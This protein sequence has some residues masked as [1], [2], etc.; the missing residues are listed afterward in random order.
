M[1]T[2]E[3]PNTQTAYFENFQLYIYDTVVLC[4]YSED[5]CN[6]VL[7]GNKVSYCTLHIHLL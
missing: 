7:N 3:V 4:G 2:F 6:G 1:A 5:V